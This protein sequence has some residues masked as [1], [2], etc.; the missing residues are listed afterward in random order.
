MPKNT[1]NLD[2]GVWRISIAGRCGFGRSGKKLSGSVRSVLCCLARHIFS[3]RDSTN[4]STYISVQTIAELTGFSV[5]TVIRALA[6]LVKEG[7]ITRH[8]RDGNLR[9]S[10]LTSLD[11]EAILAG[12][13]VTTYVA[14]SAEWEPRDGGREEDAP[15]VGIPG[16]TAMPSPEEVDAIIGDRVPNGLTSTAKR[17][18]VKPSIDEQ[19]SV[20]CK[21]SVAGAPDEYLNATVRL[22]EKTFPNHDNVSSESKLQYLRQNLK[23][24]VEFMGSADGLYKL[25]CPVFRDQTPR[26]LQ[27]MAKLADSKNLANY[28]QG[29]LKRDLL[30]RF[31]EAGVATPPQQSQGLRQPFVSIIEEDDD[32]PDDQDNDEDEDD[33]QDFDAWE[34]EDDRLEE[35]VFNEHGERELPRGYDPFKE[36]ELPP[37]FDLFEEMDPSED[38]DYDPDWDN[39]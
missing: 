6:T 36:R 7:L 16:L 9:K 2:H 1:P 8:L 15:G 24:S 25:C 19:L 26:G 30:T 31:D 38:P 23:Q 4:C 12:R 39:H 11:W 14:K 37:G 28:L 22:I 3:K 18:S 10:R 21:V 5:D 34:D 33:D 27:T 17:A 29:S 13:V 35:V 32:D 20:S